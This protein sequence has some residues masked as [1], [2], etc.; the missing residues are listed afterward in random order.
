MPKSQ[1]I[2]SDIGVLITGGAGFVGSAIVDAVME[3]YPEC[4]ITVL[5]IQPE[6]D[7][8][9]LKPAR[10]AYLRVDLRVAVEVSRAVALVKPTVVVHT[11][12]LIPA[13]AERYRRTSRL[14]VNRMNVQ[15]TLNILGAA[16]ACG[17]AAFIYTSSCC[18]VTDDLVCDYPNYNEETPIPTRSLIYG[19]SKVARTSHWSLMIELI[20]GNRRWPKVTS[21][22]RTT[23]TSQRVLSVLQSS[24]V[25][26]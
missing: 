15:G 10:V 13:G 20:I 5:D 14:A 4:K 22:K 3:K 21:S 1:E 12:G 18:V 16:K 25:N 8:E 7:Y 24:S 11:A 2:M 6:E 9:K 17:V 19:E 26:G 23:Q